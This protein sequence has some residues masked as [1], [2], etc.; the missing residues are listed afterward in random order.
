MGG[1]IPRGELELVGVWLLW[2]GQQPS[3]LAA[4]FLLA[5]TGGGGHYS[6][7]NPSCLTLFPRYL[8]RQVK[9]QM[10]DELTRV[11]KEARLKGFELIKA[12]Y[13]DSVPFRQV[14]ADC[15]LA[16]GSQAAGAW[17]AFSYKERS[18]VYGC[19]GF[20]PLDSL[21]VVY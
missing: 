14:P 7:T 17:H 18:G 19:A 11:A 9:K 10:L 8:L 16:S 13:V 5:A 12:V 4:S 1:S 21:L 2:Q 20:P 3:L 15:A 6:H